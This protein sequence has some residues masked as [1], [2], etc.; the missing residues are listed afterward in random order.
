M[1]IYPSMCG[2]LGF[3]ETTG[4]AVD[5]SE[6]QAAGRRMA[7]TLA[8]RGPDDEGL[9][10]DPDTPLLLG[11][12]RLSII[13]LTPEGH[14]PMESVS[15]RYVISFNGEIYNFPELQKELLAL[16]AS[17]RGR[18]D[19][20]VMLAA[21][22]MWGLNRALPKLEGMFAFALWDRKERTIHL[23][24]DRLGKKPLY[25]GWIGNSL[26]FASELKALRAYSDFTP[27]VSRDA[28]ALYMRYACLPAPHSIYKGVWQ[29]LPGCRLA[30]GTDTAHA[31]SDLSQKMEPYWQL[32]RVVDEARRRASPLSEAAALEKFESLLG[33]CVRERML[34]DVPLG[35]FLSGGID[36]SLVVALMQRESQRPVKTFTVGFKE[37]AFD[38]AGHA[39][40]VAAHLGTDHQEI[41]LGEKE[42]LAIVPELSALYDEPFADASQIPTL[43]VSRFARQSVTV[44][45]S[46]DGGDELMGGYIRHLSVPALARKIRF[47]PAAL[48]RTAGKAV[49]AAGPGFWSKAAP[50]HPQFGERV[51]KMAEFFIRY[52]A[53][54]AYDS[55]T[56]PWSARQNIVRGARDLT[57]PLHDPSWQPGNNLSPAER[58]IY[59]DTL[60]YLPN[61]ILV[62][63]DRAS[64]AAS[65]EVRA[66]LL[67][68]RLFEYAWSL[69]LNMKIR[70]GRGKWLLR[71]TLSQH[72]PPDLFERTKQGFSVPI[73]AWLR[74][75]LKDWAAALLDQSRIR[76]E[77][78]LDEGIVST[79]WQDHLRG[80]G[81]HAARLWTILMFQSWAERWN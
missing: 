36:S 42:A 28:L 73:A 59:K 69:P 68:R 49:A 14:Q 74:G 3:F 22:D 55:V 17:F 31:G 7:A 60:S 37:S 76:N 63:V 2:I 81:N 48:R 53:E 57:F 67:D 10:Q 71:R 50:H 26:V 38:E 79:T 77:D 18:S 25:V 61:D 5:R 78:F 24:R 16:G 20:E 47:M 32:P 51:H 52:G 64:M 34:S 27:E 15:G 44:A 30:L 40:K 39:R 11:H 80:H 19:T 41:L 33:N 13:D 62:K 43:L 29:L 6:L 23:V 72:V 46:G 8:H 35:A 4:R 66:P 65:L 45:L 56:C 21:F 54:D 9:W 70:Q 58:L 75:P 1:L 12:R